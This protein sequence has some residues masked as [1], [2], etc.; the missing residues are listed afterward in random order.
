MSG[1]FGH[2]MSTSWARW[3]TRQLP[4]ETAEGRRDE[5]ASDLWEHAADAERRGQRRWVHEFEVIGRVLSGL[6]ADLSW[7]RGILRSLRRPES[8]VPMS[9]TNHS[10]GSSS[11]LLTI[12]VGIGIAIGTTSILIGASFAGEMSGVEFVWTALAVT[13]TA[14]LGAGLA[15]RPSRPQASTALLTIGAAAPAVAWFWLP[16]IYLLSAA[17]VIAT[18]A[19]RG[20]HRPVRTAS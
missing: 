6:P 4:G 20:R 16:P 15:L 7:R 11:L 17:I 13:L 14:L 18:I 5:L 8:G 12:L 2:R 19:T 9:T 10:T 1:R 3:Y